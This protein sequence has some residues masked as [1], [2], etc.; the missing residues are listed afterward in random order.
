M[1]N[2][3][4]LIVLFFS[5]YTI[6]KGQP[7]PSGRQAT[8]EETRMEQRIL[9]NIRATVMQ[10]SSC[11]TPTKK[12]HKTDSNSDALTSTIQNLTRRIE[13]LEKSLPPSIMKRFE[14]LSSF[15]KIELNPT[16]NMFEKR[17]YYVGLQYY[18]SWE[19]AQFQCQLA[20]A[21]LLTDP[22]TELMDVLFE[23]FQS[24]GNKIW[25]YG[26]KTEGTFK[27]ITNGKVIDD[28]DARWAPA[29]PR[30]TI[31]DTCIYV[32]Q[33]TKKWYDGPC[34]EIHHFVCES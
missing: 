21:N 17:C 28:N 16:I 22:S 26:N 14:C 31:N 20:G 13:V 19:N 10:L 12:L 7:L 3:T 24:N 29:L 15:E 30:P 8:V 11:E 32:Y 18:L 9:A 27:W 2:P 4:F 23:T 1:F 6:S 33:D 25:L 5:F 34:S